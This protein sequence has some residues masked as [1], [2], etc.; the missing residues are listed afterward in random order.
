M[1]FPPTK[2]ARNSDKAV[3][4]TSSPV[5]IAPSRGLCKCLFGP[6][7]PKAS[8]DIARMAQ[9]V[10]KQEK[11]RF[12]ARWGL[13][14]LNF[15][16]NTATPTITTAAKPTD[17][18]EQEEDEIEKNEITKKTSMYKWEKVKNENI[19][20]FYYKQITRSTTVAASSADSLES[21]M[22][23]LTCRNSTER[24]PSTPVKRRYKESEAYQYRIDTGSAEPSPT[25]R[26][27]VSAET[28]TGVKS[29]AVRQL[30]F[31]IQPSTDVKKTAS[32]KL[33]RH[34]IRLL[35]SIPA[36]PTGRKAPTAAP[37]VGKS[38]KSASSRSESNTRSQK[39]ITDLMCVR[40]KRSVLGAGKKTAS[41]HKAPASLPIDGGKL[42]ITT[43]KS[44]SSSLFGPPPVARRVSPSQ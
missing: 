30:N 34:A 21:R 24:V 41:E 20:Y 36:A 13:E 14:S 7:D 37:V 5:G 18:E 9:E 42:A 2:V 19:P 29:P 44:A 32:S 4:A 12:K 8:S 16:T 35:T 25:K 43:T 23:P 28:T 11:S 15:S 31:D 40:K 38:K 26:S 6:P 27:H 22:R 39:L 33:H 17:S 1:V 10:S 3:R